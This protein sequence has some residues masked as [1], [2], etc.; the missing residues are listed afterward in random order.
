MGVTQ[1]SLRLRLGAVTSVPNE[2]WFL[3]VLEVWWALSPRRIF[4]FFGPACPS[5]AIVGSALR[6]P[7]LPLLLAL[8]PPPPSL[9]PLRPLPLPP[10]LPQPPPPR[11]PA[12]PSR[13][14]R[15]SSPSCLGRRR[16]PLPGVGLA[17]STATSIAA[18]VAAAR[19][20][21]APLAAFNSITHMAIHTAATGTSTSSNFVIACAGTCPVTAGAARRLPMFQMYNFDFHEGS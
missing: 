2:H 7:P 17:T 20:I 12:S 4:F 11:L 9:P 15:P 18:V 21:G 16:P 3:A 6:P 19:P 10:P 5:L 8:R 13:R 14:A 1:R